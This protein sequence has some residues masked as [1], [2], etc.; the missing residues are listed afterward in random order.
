MAKY[1]PRACA[2]GNERGLFEHNRNVLRK[3]STICALCGMPLDKS[4]KYPHPLSTSI[5]HIIPV[6]LGGRSTLD[7]LQATHLQCNKEK[8]KKILINSKGQLDTT[9]LPHTSNA[10]KNK[11]IPQYLDWSN[12]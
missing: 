2:V 4:L 7:N 10:E 1:K 3:T 11:K 12:Y 8:G 9:T 5:D 6:A